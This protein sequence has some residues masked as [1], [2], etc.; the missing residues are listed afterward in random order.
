MPSSAQK[1]VTRAFLWEKL[2]QRQ[3]YIDW[4][5]TYFEGWS[6]SN[7]NNLGLALGMKLKLEILHQR[8]KV[9]IKIRKFWSL[10]PT[11]V[12]VTREKLVGGLPP[13]LNRAKSTFDLMEKQ[14]MNKYLKVSLWYHLTLNRCLLPYQSQKQ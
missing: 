14:K 11:F 4:K 8:V 7:F 12:N 10:I 13:I 9:E 2:R 3:F 6:F 5:T 1:L